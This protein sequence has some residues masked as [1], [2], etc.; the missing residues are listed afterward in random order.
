MPGGGGAGGLAGLW[1]R[2]VNFIQGNYLQAATAEMQY[3]CTDL[4]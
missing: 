2:G 3:E 1:Q 4:T